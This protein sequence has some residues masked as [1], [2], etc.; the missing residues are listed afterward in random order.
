MQKIQQKFDQAKEKALDELNKSLPLP[1][2]S[3]EEINKVFNIWRGTE[4]PIKKPQDN[5]DT[6]K[7]K[8]F[9]I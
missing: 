6:K 7:D 3:P 9:S 2:P 1:N 5:N 8:T 4:T